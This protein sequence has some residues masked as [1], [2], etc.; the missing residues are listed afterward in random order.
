[1]NKNNYVSL[2]FLLDRSGSIASCKL[3][4]EGGFNTLIQK[5]KN[6]KVGR[7]DV[8]LYQFDNVLETVYENKDISEVSPLNIDPRGGTALLDSVC[9]TIDLFGKKL[10]NKEEKDRPSKVIFIILTDGEENSSKKFS[11]EDVKSRIKHQEEKY[12]WDFLFLGANID[13]WAVGDS[14]GLSHRSTYSYASNGR[15]KGISTDKMYNTISN[16]LSD[17]RSAVSMGNI[18][19]KVSFTIEEQEE[20]EKLIKGN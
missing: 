2:V 5:Q 1:M 11:E 8:S 17:S 14:L 6:D 18:T 4:L 15:N 10:S 12:N 7:L 3:D 9:E 13:T 16:K 20:Q 19:A